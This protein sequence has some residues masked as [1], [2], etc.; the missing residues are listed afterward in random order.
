MHYGNPGAN[1]M[2]WNLKYRKEEIVLSGCR[3]LGNLGNHD[4][5]HGWRVFVE[6]AC[7]FKEQ[8]D[9]VWISL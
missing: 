1:Y 9:N 7:G 8:K 5:T 3:V 2:R 6:V 4:I